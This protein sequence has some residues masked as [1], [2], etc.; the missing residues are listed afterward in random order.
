DQ[1]TTRMR[2]VHLIQYLYRNPDASGEDWMDPKWKVVPREANLEWPYDILAPKLPPYMAFSELV[3]FS[4]RE[5]AWTQCGFFPVE[6]QPSHAFKV[7][8]PAVRTITLKLPDVLEHLNVLVRDIAPTW[9]S[10]ENQHR[11]KSILLKIYGTI[12]KYIASSINHQVWAVQRATEILKCPYILN[13]K[14]SSNRSSWL[15]P[16]QL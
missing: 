10:T 1:T 15:W 4:I 8:F 12:N 14:V 7:R 9:T 2:A 13:G 16:K 6:L 5:I 11:L 3:G